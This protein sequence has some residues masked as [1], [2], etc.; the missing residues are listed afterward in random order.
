MLISNKGMAYEWYES[1][2]KKSETQ[3]RDGNEI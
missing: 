3:Y 1:G 2:A